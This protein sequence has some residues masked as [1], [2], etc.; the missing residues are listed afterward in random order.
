MMLVLDA[1]KKILETITAELLQASQKK[2]KTNN[3]LIHGMR[4]MGKTTI[5]RKL[6]HDIKDDEAL[7]NYYNVTYIPASFSGNE[8]VSEIRKAISTLDVRQMKKHQILMV[9]DID[10]AFE[11]SENE[12]H[13]LREILIQDSPRVSV[14]CT[15]RMNFF[16]SLGYNEAMYG[17][18]SVH[19]L[20]LVSSDDMSLAFL[21]DVVTTPVWNK[22]NKELALVNTFWVMVLTDNNPRLL[23]TLSY[24]LSSSISSPTPDSLLISYFEM[25]ESHFMVELMRLSPYARYFLEEASYSGQF[26]KIKELNLNIK[27]PAREA[28]KLVDIG[29]LKKHESG[30]YSFVQRPLKAWLRYVKQ[31]PLGKVLNV[32][33]PVSRHY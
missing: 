4:G 17:F 32:D 20:D 14:I 23:R 21:E 6:S 1:Q 22:M 29:L 13:K 3:H 10:L 30:E 26:F 12:S 19:N 28:T 25:I 5:L 33:I 7:S 18:F 9:D 2:I 27:N 16:A 15:A 11:G 8:F 31:L 24:I